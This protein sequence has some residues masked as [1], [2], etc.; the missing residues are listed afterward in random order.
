MANS[1]KRLNNS[2]SN[3]RKTHKIV[4]TE[5][6]FKMKIPNAKNGDVVSI[7]ANDIKDNYLIVN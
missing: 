1:K 7:K 2:R 3:S 5:N 4:K 6:N